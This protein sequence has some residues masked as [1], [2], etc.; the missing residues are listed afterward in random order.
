MSLRS[1]CFYPGILLNC[2]I[3][4]EYDKYYINKGG[5]WS[6]ND[7]IKEKIQKTLGKTSKNEHYIQKIL[8]IKR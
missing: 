1:K 7:K 5:N 4:T 6:K 8:I 3:Q 2:F